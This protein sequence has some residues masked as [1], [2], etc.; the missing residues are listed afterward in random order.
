MISSA[1][2]K[3]DFLATPK[4]GSTFLP[5]SI[6]LSVYL[7]QESV[8]SITASSYSP[9]VTLFKPLVST[10]ADALI[11]LSCALSTLSNSSAKSSL[12]CLIVSFTNLTVGLASLTLPAT[13]IDVL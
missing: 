4:I 12:P 5:V 11:N 10:F 6:I 13:P 2:W 1:D 3:S 7:S 8:N 9:L